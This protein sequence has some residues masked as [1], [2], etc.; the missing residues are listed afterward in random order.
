MKMAVIILLLFFPALAF[1]GPLIR[2]ESETHYFGHADGEW[3]EYS[4]D[5]TNAGSEEL[6]IQR[7]SPP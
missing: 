6:V 1:A 4:F 2:F 3:A 7:I 5:F